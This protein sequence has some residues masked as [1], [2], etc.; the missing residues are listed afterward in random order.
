MR[1]QQHWGKAVNEVA[2]LVKRRETN[3]KYKN[4]PPF[5]GGTLRLRLPVDR[6]GRPGP[7][8]GCLGVAATFLR[9]EVCRHSFL[10]VMP[11]GR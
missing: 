6:P 10:E 11:S 5:L 1:R 9:T 2:Q 3:I 8:S 7:V 4:P